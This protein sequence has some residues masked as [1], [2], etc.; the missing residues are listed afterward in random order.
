MRPIKFRIWANLDKKMLTSTEEIEAFAKEQWEDIREIKLW[1]F[2]DLTLLQFTWL[3]D[4]DG[5][6]IYEGDI[7]QSEVGDIY[8]VKF[9]PPCFFFVENWVEYVFQQY[10]MD[11]HWM[12]IIGNIHENPEL[13]NP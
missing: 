5:K 9:S 8:Q 1:A 12:E 6:E 3:L 4:K 2:S 11:L 7:I 13:L 10:A